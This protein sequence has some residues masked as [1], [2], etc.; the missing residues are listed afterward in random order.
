M[1][2]IRQPGCVSVRDTVSGPD[3]AWLDTT[4][5]STINRYE[6]DPG[7]VPETLRI[8][9]I[10][11]D[12]LVRVAEAATGKTYAE[13]AFTDDADPEK[14]ICYLDS[15]HDGGEPRMIAVPGLSPASVQVT[16]IPMRDQFG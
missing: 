4:S 5:M 15:T 10:R 11:E 16:G 8:Y 13:H 9:D 12:A 7:L 6:E 14:Y 3:V 2:W 1:A